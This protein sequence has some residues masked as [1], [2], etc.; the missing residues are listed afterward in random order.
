[1]SK[2]IKDLVTKELVAKYKGVDSACV[3]DL[4][5]LDSISTHKFRGGLR[6]KK[7]Q[8]HV[9]KNRMARRAFDGGPLAPLG[10]Y[11]QGPCALATGGDSIVDVA[12]ELVALAKNVPAI[13]L[14]KAIVE[15]DADL[16]D[17]DV[18]AKWKSR[19]E[20]Q[21]EVAMLTASPGRRL[22]GC[23]GGPAARIAGCVKAI[24]EKAQPEGAEATA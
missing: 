18:L 1:M 6:K 4:T 10:K 11:L 13:K 2:P 3:V 15:G 19:A 12:K 22:A 21:G 7:I 20:T 5:G 23:I 14:K 16:V 9:V 8:L 17:V 24:V